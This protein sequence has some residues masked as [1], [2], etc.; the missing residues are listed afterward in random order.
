MKPIYRM[1]VKFSCKHDDIKG[2]IRR[3]GYRN[4]WESMNEGLTNKQA[5]AK[6]KQL[7]KKE[8]KSQLNG[9]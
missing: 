9:S 8:I 6:E 2:A 7:V 3:L 4:W 1:P 5:R